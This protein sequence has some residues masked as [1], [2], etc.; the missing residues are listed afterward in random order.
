[1]RVVAGS[2]KGRHLKSPKSDGTR[3]VID[4]VK[5]A[6]FDIL[7]PRMVDTRFLDLFAGSGGMGSRRSAAAHARRP[8]WS[9]TRRC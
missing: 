7:A 4:R 9:W 1:M 5:T 6:L 8:S 2:A 3:P